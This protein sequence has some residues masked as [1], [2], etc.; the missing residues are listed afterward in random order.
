MPEEP[1]G[2]GRQERTIGELVA[3]ISGQFSGLIRGELELAQVNL[4]EKFSKIGVGGA[5]LAVA[6]IL[7]LYMLGTLL[8][9]AAWGLAEVMPVWAGYLIVSGVLLLLVIILAVIGKRSIDK[10]KEFEIAPQ[11]GVKKS[12]DAAKM[13]IKK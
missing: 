5:I 4:K 13:G 7:A 9:A 11:E 6:G 12:I 1:T 10:S 8:A 2:T 3:A